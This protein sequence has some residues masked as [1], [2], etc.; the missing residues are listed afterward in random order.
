[1]CKIKEVLRLQALGLKQEQIAR[2]CGISQS[3]VSEYQAA[4]SAAG[5]HWDEIADWNEVR[6]QQELFPNR[7]PAARGPVNASPD[8]STIHQQLQKHKNQ[9][10]VGRRTGFAAESLALPVERNHVRQRH[11]RHGFELSRQGQPVYVSG[12]NNGFGCK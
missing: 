9:L 6:I 5:V 3:T 8:F 10:R 2:S 11:K 4:A 12:R 1:M 7:K